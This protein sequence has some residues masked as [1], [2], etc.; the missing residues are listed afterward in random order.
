MPHLN[1]EEILTDPVLL[2]RTADDFMKKD[3]DLCVLKE[4]QEYPSILQIIEKH[5]KDQE[6]RKILLLPELNY[7]NETVAVFSDYGGESK[8]SRYNTYS[9]LVCALDHTYPF[10][11]MMTFIRQK[12]GLNDKE[13]SFKDFKYGPVSRA[14]DDYLSALNLIPGLLF[15]VVV[16]KEADSISPSEI[17]EIVKTL[18][19]NNM[20]EWKSGVVEKLL[21][22]CNISAYLVSLLIANGQKVF[23]M[24]DHDAIAANDNLKNTG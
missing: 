22:I 15:T 19:D 20:G 11:G 2:A 17:K 21:R 12:Y 14:L 4:T 16:E 24:T 18:K 6:R 7:E 9:F 3:Y 13:I 10:N 8:D 5:F 1:W 23:W